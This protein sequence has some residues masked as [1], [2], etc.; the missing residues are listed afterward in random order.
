M[1]HWRTALVAALLCLAIVPATYFAWTQRDMPH[2]GLHHDDEI[3]WVSAWSLAQGHGYTI[4]SLPNQLAQTKYPILYPLLLAGIWKAAPDYPG[5]LPWA[6]LLSWACGMGYLGLSWL[7]L[8]QWELPP[9]FRAAVCCLIGMSPMFVIVSTS[10]MTELLF[11]TLVLAS[12]WLAEKAVDDERMAFAAAAGACAG[13]AYLTRSLALPLL[14]TTPL[15]FVLQRRP[16]LA[17]LFAVSMLP[18]LAGWQ[19]FTIP[20]LQPSPGLVARYYTDYVALRR[21]HVP[22]DLWPRVVWI[23]SDHV[24][25]SIGRSLTFVPEL[26]FFSIQ[27]LRFLGLVAVIGSVRLCLR[28][29]RWHGGLGSLAMAALLAIWIYPPDTRFLLPLL[30]LLIAGFYTEVVTFYELVIKTYRRNKPGDRV[31]AVMLGAAASVALA[32]LIWGQASPNWQ[33]LPRVYATQRGI[34]EVRLRANAWVKANTAVEVNVWSYDDGLVFLETGHRGATVPMIPELI[35][36]DTAQ[37]LPKFIHAFPGFLD[38]HH[39]SL[40]LFTNHDF[41]RDLQEENRRKFI[42]EV[43][44]S[45]RFKPLIATKEFEIY[46]R[47]P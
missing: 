16:K 22:F 8:R 1:K 21:F 28:T 25:A 14:V 30:V 2:L 37:E 11:G 44:Q 41:H 9:L 34:R 36:R 39:L 10:I 47:L 32:Y 5:N 7:M 26:N 46:Q 42:A 3:Y 31:V 13:L 24:I 35:Y 43:K 20:H 12:F 27:A 23:N 29:R 33:F 15:I 18:F 17:G 38:E 6:M 40:V 45:G 19:L 4:A